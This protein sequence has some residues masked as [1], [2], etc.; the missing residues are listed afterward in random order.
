MTNFI[1]FNNYRM[2]EVFEQYIKKMIPTITKEQITLMQSKCI[3]KK[4][5]KKEMV[6]QEGEVSMYKLFVVKGLLRNYSIADNGNEYIVRFADAGS[7]TT[8]PESYYSGLPSKYNIDAIEPSEVLMFSHD[9]YEALKQQ[10]PALSSFSEMV[11]TANASFIQ[12]RVLMNI[13]ATAEEKYID[14]IHS[15]PHIFHRVPLHMVA[16]YLGVSRETLTRVRQGL[17]IGAKDF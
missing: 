5:R 11:I 13:S 1:A 14:F 6:L 16:S 17:M 2:F 9:N 15:F 12:N 10:I 7:W 8:D 3:K 4:L